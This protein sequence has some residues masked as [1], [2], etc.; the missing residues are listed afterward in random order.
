MTCDCFLKQILRVG[1]DRCVRPRVAIVTFDDGFQL[2]HQKSRF[3][4]CVVWRGFDGCCRSPAPDSDS[5]VFCDAV[6]RP[7]RLVRRNTCAHPSHREV[8][9]LCI[10]V[11]EVVTRPSMTNSASKADHET[12]VLAISMGCI[13]TTFLNITRFDPNFRMIYQSTILT[14]LCPHI[15]TVEAALTSPV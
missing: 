15:N 7:L 1:A 2:L 3:A 5:F 11:S 12:V 13:P 14:S 10:F 6:M 4:C 9:M 8:P